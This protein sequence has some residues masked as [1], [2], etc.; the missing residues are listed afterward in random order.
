[1]KKRLIFVFL[2]LCV[3][4][5]PFTLGACP[6]SNGEGGD[7]SL[8]SPVTA[9]IL[10]TDDAAGNTDVTILARYHP[11]SGELSVM[12]IPRDTYLE[13]RFAASKINHLFP[14][15]LAQGMSE[16]AALAEVSAMLSDALSVPIDFAVA[17]R[18][19]AL[20]RLVDEIGGVSITVPMDMTYEDPEAGVS[21][22][23][24]K[25]EQ[26]LD[27]QAAC[28]FVRYRSGYLEGDLGRVD[29]Q[30]LFLSA[31]VSQAAERIDL[32]HLLSLLTRPPE[33]LTLSGDKIRMVYV[34]QQFYR[35]RA[36]LRAVYFSAPGEAVPP[37]EG[38]AWYYAINRDAM[39][40]LLCRYFAL[41]RTSA[42]D[43][44]GRFCGKKLQFENI[45]FASGYPYRV[46]T[47]EEVQDI[48][49]KKKE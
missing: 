41:P 23:L 12:Q 16:K 33:G 26:T 46:Y 34:A 38:G 31:F 40:T 47:A 19:S 37:H 44:T 13:S 24:K 39:A 42:F 27:G 7:N 8:L 9:L 1:M 49:I 20:S 3:G 11:A 2:I 4:L 36:H 10:G 30:K 18:P 29:A 14:A 15:L 22:R 6:S 43:E 32:S 48:I 21:I 17:L 35:N 28:E 5:V 45:Y 25:G